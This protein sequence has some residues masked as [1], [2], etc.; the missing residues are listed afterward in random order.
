MANENILEIKKSEQYRTVDELFKRSQSNSIYYT[1][2][3]ISS[4]IVASGLLLGNAFIVIGGM[5]LTPVLSPVLLV[6]LGLAIGD[7]ASIRRV[8]M[9]VAKSIVVIVLSSLILT[10]L[11]GS[12]TEIPFFENT[13]RTAILYFIVAL[14]SGVAATFAWVRKEISEILPGI[15]IAVSLVPPLSM[16]GIG[17]ASFSADII[18]YHFFVFLFN[19]I[20]IIVGSLIVFLLLKF[21]KSEKKIQKEVKKVENTSE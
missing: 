2:L 21:Y 12:P 4:L 14:A 15:A 16:M 5:L 9:L 1:L 7:P 18:H 11:F 6:A 17:F 19:L 20:G 8:A 3:A 13:T 10:F